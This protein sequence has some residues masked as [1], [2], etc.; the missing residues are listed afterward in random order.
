MNVHHLELFY[1]VAR[2]GGVSA[3]A[4]AMPYGIQQPAISAQILQLEDVLGVT[5]YQR[6]PFQLTREGQA[7][8]DFIAPFFSGLAEMADRIRGGGEKRLRISAAEIVQRDYLPEL[9]ARMRQRVKG[10]H[11]TLTHGRQQEIEAL[12]AAQE[13]D[14]GLSTLMDKTAANIEARELLR[15][16]MVLLVPKQS[17]LT[18]AA[19]IFEKDRIDLPLVAL[20]AKDVISRSFQAALRQR[21][22]EWLP[23]LEV[24]SLDLVVRYVAEGFGAGLALRHPRVELPAGV[25]ALALDDFPP[26]SFGALWTGRLS[27]LG[28]AFLA[29]ATTLA[30]EL[31]A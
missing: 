19:Q 26:L 12:L 17:G 30:G 2:H 31:A 15:L 25:K 8:H 24:G 5:L 3:A 14:I 16:P 29:E 20:E 6:R 13:I 28:E 4:R 9:L 18:K 10:F 27:P 22:L 11:F 23:S 7:L 1:Y 21:S